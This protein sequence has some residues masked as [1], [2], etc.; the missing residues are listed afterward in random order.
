MIAQSIS[1]KKLV[2]LVV[3]IA[4]MEKQIFRMN[5]GKVKINKSGF[6]K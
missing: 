5:G 4:I 1:E 3:P 6:H 2:S